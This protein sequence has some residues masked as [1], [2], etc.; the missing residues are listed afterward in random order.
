MKKSFD[1][2]LHCYRLLQDEPFFA[3]LSRKVEKIAD[4]SIPTAGV[5]VNPNSGVFE[6][7]YNPEFMG[8]LP[9][10][11]I[12]GVLKHEFY[13]LIFDHVTTR[14]PERATQAVEHRC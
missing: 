12:K 1:L 13:H 4:P 5:W 10:E 9:E 7:R 14:K 3:A 6:M 2:N 8:G 11:H